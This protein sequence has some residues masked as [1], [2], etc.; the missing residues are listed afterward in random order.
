[1][2]Q[3]EKIVSYS[4]N[5]LPEM[6]AL[7]VEELIN[8]RF[9]GHYIILDSTETKKVCSPIT[10][11]LNILLP[12][13]G[14]TCICPY[15]FRQQS[16]IVRG[17]ENIIHSVQKGEVLEWKNIYEG[18]IAIA[19]FVPQE[20]LHD[21]KVK[22]DSHNSRFKNGMMTKSDNRIRLIINQILDLNS[23]VTPL[24]KLR[25]Q[26]HIIEAIVHQIE[27]LY[28]ENE[29]HEIIINKNHYDK[30]LLA[31]ALIE[32]DFTQSY[33]IQEIAKKIGTNEQYLKKYF[34]QYFGKT[35]MNYMTDVKME[36]ARKLIMTGEYRVSD[37]ARLT[38]Y[39]HAT[40]FTTAFK[41]YFGFIPNSLRY[42]FLIASEGV[43]IVSEI[44]NFLLAIGDK[45]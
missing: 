34:K 35:V 45:I 43:S 7:S 13:A 17:G 18:N 39:K 40:H 4:E 21:F 27:G 44:E 38:G 2:T 31:K 36:H 11:F 14:N 41:K 5:N 1:M 22:F 37:V 19:I 32:K 15:V 10:G 29:K 26:A 20:M 42:T 25:I 16:F 23:I 33:T 24:N 3:S 12:S 28:A 8:T 6:E 9:I 30:I